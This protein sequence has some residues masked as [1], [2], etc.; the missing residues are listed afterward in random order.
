MNQSLSASFRLRVKQK[1][2]EKIE[3]KERRRQDREIQNR[4]DPFFVNNTNTETPLTSS[5]ST[6]RYSSQPDLTTMSNELPP[7]TTP[8]RTADP[9]ITMTTN[10]NNNN[11]SILPNVPS[12][13]R[14]RA[15][16]NS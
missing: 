3:Q 14:F 1:T 16:K 7:A 6:S 8:K 12:Q 5:T 13:Q 2:Q 15:F 10:N 4:Q 11:S 9:S